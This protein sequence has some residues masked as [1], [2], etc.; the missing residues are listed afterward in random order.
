MPSILIDNMNLECAIR[1]V[2]AGL[3]GAAIG[4]ERTKRS[5]GAGIRT[6]ILVAIGAALF[7]IISK[8][9]F[10]DVV[11]LEGTQVD[12]SR[13]ASNIVS[14]ISFLGAGIIFMRG[15]SIQGLTTAAGIWVTAAIGLS[16]GSGMY[17]VGIIATAVI[18]FVQV[19]LH[20][21]V[22][23][24]MDNIISTRIVVSMQDDPIKFA[25]FQQILKGRQIEIY[26]SHVKRHKDNSLTYTLEVRMPKNISNRE[27]LGLIRDYSIVKSIGY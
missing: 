1:L 10:S 18:L 5:K 22:F 24:G 19:L 25:E 21:G 4:A 6:H 15:D 3:C 27:L 12:V 2:V 14:G 7:V 26:G 8:Y 9:G 13:V 20:R 16:V 17:F 23:Q 11:G